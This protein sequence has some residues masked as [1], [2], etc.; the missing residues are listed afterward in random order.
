MRAA[1]LARRYAKALADVASDQH[2]LEAVGRDLHTVVETIK[3]TREITIFFASPAVPL[4]DKRRVLHTIAEGTGVKPLTANFLNLILE[5]RRFAHLGEIV[6][7]YEELTD[8]RLGRG[9]A[10]VTSAAPLPEPIMRGLKERLKAATGK[11]IY[12]EAQVDPAIVGGFVAQIGSTIYD[13]SVRTQLKRV[14][15]HLLKSEYR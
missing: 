11:E 14:R 12:L 10:T 5:K 3:R 9:K 6:L 7:A 4:T 8:E 1:G 2:L 13:G 15:E